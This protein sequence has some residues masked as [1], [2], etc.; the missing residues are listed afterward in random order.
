MARE[1]RRSLN[2]V[3]KWKQ[4]AAAIR[5]NQADFAQFGEATSNLEARTVEVS[6]L[7]ARQSSLRAAKQDVSRNLEQALREGDAVMDLLRTAARVRYGTRSEKLIEFGMLPYRGRRR[8][9]VADGTEP[10]PAPVPA[11]EPVE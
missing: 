11:S 7:H 9:A 8:T 3:N 2:K 1:E 6:D 4:V 5:K 10:A